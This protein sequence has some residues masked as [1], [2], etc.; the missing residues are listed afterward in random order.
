MCTRVQTP[1]SSSAPIIFV[2]FLRPRRRRRR[3]SRPPSRPG[4]A[5]ENRIARSHY[6]FHQGLRIFST[7]T[8]LHLAPHVHAHTGGRVR[9]SGEHK[10]CDGACVTR[11]TVG[12]AASRN[13]REEVTPTSA[14]TPGHHGPRTRRSAVD[15]APAARKHREP[16]QPSN[17]W[18]TM[19][20]WTVA[21]VLLPAPRTVSVAFFL[22]PRTSLPPRRRRAKLTKVR[23]I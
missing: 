7:H 23:F 11:F 16:N 18:T 22:F 19:L 14:H 2:D 17:M 9:G 15:D 13:Q 10:G 1:S 8:P 4:I 12:Y 21:V 3:F 20:V 5:R 6:D